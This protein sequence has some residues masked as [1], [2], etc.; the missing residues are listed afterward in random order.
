M[1]ELLWPTVCRACG[2]RGRGRLCAACRPREL[3]P[4]PD[5][6]RGIREA[7]ALAGYHAPLGAALRHAKFRPDRS[8]TRLLGRLL[9][10]VAA[11][12]DL[13]PFD[14]VVPAPSAWTS[15]LRRGFCTATLLA[16][17]VARTVG[18][19]LAPALVL[20]RGPRQSSLDRR[21]RVR[22]LAG[23]LRSRR[24]VAGRVLLV[25][26]V[27]TTGATAG[28]CARELLGSGA[29]EIWLLVLCATRRHRDAETAAQEL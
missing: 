24:P 28:A 9:A 25:D 21:G 15:R 11:G 12:A 1:L 4:L 22:N 19:P 17:P 29:A 3:L 5:P 27:T 18:A 16:A 6:T 26:D 20:K 7:R 13:P 8:L 10:E 2:I 14:A 23:R